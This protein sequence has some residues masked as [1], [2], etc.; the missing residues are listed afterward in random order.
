MFDIINACLQ[1][2]LYESYPVYTVQKSKE[3]TTGLQ[4]QVHIY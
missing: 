3:K 1:P 2:I 4:L